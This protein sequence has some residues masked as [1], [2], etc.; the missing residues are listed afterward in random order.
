MRKVTTATCLV[1]NEPWEIREGRENKQIFCRDCRKKSE[2]SIDY[3][4]AEP[5]IPWTGDFDEHDNPMRFG[6]LHLEGQR[7]CNHKD[8]VQKAH[9]IKPI[10]TEDL[11]AEQFSTF[12]R[13]GKRRNYDQLI[14]KL[15]KEKSHRPLV[16]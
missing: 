1:C 9:I 5:C 15:K 4:L 13:T 12:Y 11:I 14:A 8:C 7:K 2:T 3:G 10:N 6:E 16:A